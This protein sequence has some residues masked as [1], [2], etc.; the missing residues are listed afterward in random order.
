MSPFKPFKQFLLHAAVALAIMGMAGVVGA[1]LV[2]YFGLYNIAAVAQHT[3]PVYTVLDIALR[4]SIRQRAKHIESPS[5]EDKS[6]IQAGFVRYHKNCVPCHGAPGIAPGDAGKGM[7]PLP[8]NLVESGRELT[9][10]EI[11]WVVSNGIKMTGMPAWQYR[12][13]DDE[14]WSIVAFVKYLPAL[15]PKDYRSMAYSINAMETAEAV[16]RETQ[17][18]TNYLE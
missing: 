6:L 3:L 1:A 14:I 10:A 8:T 18:S 15:S 17:S 11:F 16:S 2:V 12:F 13:R 7:L 9:S 5:L 4:Q